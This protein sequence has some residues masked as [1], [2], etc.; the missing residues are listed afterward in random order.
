ME[1]VLGGKNRLGKDSGCI[2][3]DGGT[4][5][6]QGMQSVYRKQWKRKGRETGAPIT[7]ARGCDKSCLGR[8]VGQLCPE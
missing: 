3:N 8:S 5:G 4:G 7:R 2:V 1:C 6:G